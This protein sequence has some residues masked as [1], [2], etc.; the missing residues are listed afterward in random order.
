MPLRTMSICLPLLSPEP[1]LPI[2]PF[3]FSVGPQHAILLYPWPNR[4][5][6]DDQQHSNLRENGVDRMSPL[7]GYI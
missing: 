4:G 7:V 5:Q 1:R 6:L 3:V 2:A